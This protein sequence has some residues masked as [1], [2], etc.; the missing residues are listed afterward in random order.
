MFL[1]L[2]FSQDVHKINIKTLLREKNDK[3]SL[4]EDFLKENLRFQQASQ[5]VFCTWKWRR[6]F[7][8]AAIHKKL[9]S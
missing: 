1:C 5:A 2:I 3:K 6:H 4:L 7:L 9:S 8:S